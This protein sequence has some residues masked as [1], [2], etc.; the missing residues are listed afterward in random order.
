MYEGERSLLDKSKAKKEY[1]ELMTNITGDPTFDYAYD[2]NIEYAY[3][4]DSSLMEKAAVELFSE[5]T[6]RLLPVKRS[7]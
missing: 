6:C 2:I 4:P 5:T 7:V 3:P 1:N